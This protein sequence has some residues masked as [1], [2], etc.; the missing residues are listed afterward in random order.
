MPKS[1]PQPVVVQG[2][3]VSL[4]HSAM[5]ELTDGVLSGFAY[6][7]DKAKSAARAKTGVHLP[8][9]KMKREFNKDKH[10][11]AAWRISFQYHNGLKLWLKRAPDYIGIEDYAL[12]EHGGHQL[13]EIGGL[14]RF[15]CM[16]SGVPFRLHDPTS[17]KMWVAHDGNCSKDTVER[18]VMERW[19]VDFRKHNPD[20]EGNDHQTSED[21]ADAY[22]IA[23]MI[24][25]EVQLRRGMIRLDSLDEKELRVVN[26]ITKAQP[27]ALL[28]R[29]WITQQDI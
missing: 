14:A 11:L 17:V 4:N 10:R 26:R 3:D 12:K 5:V 8:L 13:G 2:W 9:E 7:T 28:S 25:A 15:V 29:E 27:V 19:G 16:Q 20:P 22:G 18:A 1:K 23:Q 6:I 24:W 21:L